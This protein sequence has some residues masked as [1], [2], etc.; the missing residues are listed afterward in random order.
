MFLCLLQ[1]IGCLCS[2]NIAK[3]SALAKVSAL[4]RVA[5]T[6]EK[7]EV[8][9]SHIV[10][11]GLSE[12]ILARKTMNKNIMKHIMKNIIDNI[13]KNIMNYHYF[14]LLFDDICLE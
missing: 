6:R 7:C 8:Q 13:M 3:A 14:C 9:R 5:Q 12:A 10:A 1:Q 2:L 4:D 11:G